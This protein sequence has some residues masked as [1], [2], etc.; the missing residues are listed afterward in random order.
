MPK[1]DV[2]LRSTDKKVKLYSN[3]LVLHCELNVLKYTIEFPTPYRSK[4]FHVPC[5]SIEPHFIDTKPMDQ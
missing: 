1:M 3:T 2:D 5:D 4:K